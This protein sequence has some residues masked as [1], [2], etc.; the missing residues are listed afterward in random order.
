M[1]PRYRIADTSQIISPGLVLYKE[2]IAANLRRMLEIAG[3]PH[4]LTGDETAA[5]NGRL[6]DELLEM[7]AAVRREQGRQR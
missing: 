5:S 1:D 6:H 7:I 3:G 2:L 4:R